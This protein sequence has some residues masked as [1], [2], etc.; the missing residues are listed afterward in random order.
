[1]GCSYCSGYTRHPS[2]VDQVEA[3]DDAE[4]VFALDDTGSVED[5]KPEDLKPEE[6]LAYDP[7]KVGEDA[8]PQDTLNVDPNARPGYWCATCDLDG[9]YNEGDSCERCKTIANQ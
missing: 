5:L 3:D 1:M 2:Y 9:V 4:E 8:D 7:L 6:V